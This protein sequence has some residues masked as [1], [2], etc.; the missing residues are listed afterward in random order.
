MDVTE[1]QVFSFDVG[2]FHGSYR[3]ISMR[4]LSDITD[5]SV[6]EEGVGPYTY[7]P[8]DIN[9]EKGKYGPPR[10]YQMLDNFGSKRIIWFYNT[11]SVLP[12]RRF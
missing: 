9:I 1:R 10:T 2:T 4:R 11:F 6:S 8:V 5:Y 7:D 3:D 12:R